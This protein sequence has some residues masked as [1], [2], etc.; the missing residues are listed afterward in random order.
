MTPSD[1]CSQHD[2]GGPA[3]LEV[4]DLLAGRLAVARTD[5]LPEDWRLWLGCLNGQSAAYGAA[6]SLARY[7]CAARDFLRADCFGDVAESDPN[8]GR[9]AVLERL[10]E[11]ER[12]GS[13]VDQVLHRVEWLCF[14]HV[15]V[16]MKKPAM[17]VGESRV[18][19]GACNL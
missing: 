19:C 18:S 11:V 8:H 13:V 1:L 12:P 4:D 5:D 6:E 7:A 15:S 14:C 16:E 2:L 10:G 17:L 3:V 9:I